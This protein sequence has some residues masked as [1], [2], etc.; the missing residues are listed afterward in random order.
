VQGA[1]VQIS[2]TTSLNFGN[3]TVGVV[4]SPQSVTLMNTGNIAL[5]VSIGVTGT[6]SGDFAQ[7]NT[8]G[9]SVA[10]GGS[11]S[12]TVTFKPLATGT[13]SAAVTITD[14]AQNSPQAVS[15]TGVGVQGAVTL[16]PTSLTFPTQVIFTTSTAQ[17][18]TL[19]N[20]GLGVLKITKGTI[21]GP[22]SYSSNCGTSVNPGNSCTLTVVFKPTTIGALTGSISITDN[23]PLSPQTIALSGTGTSVKFTPA[24]LNFGNQ[25]VGTTSLRKII[26][27]SN[28]GSVALNVSGIT[29]TGTNATDF[30]QVNNCGTSVAAGASCSI[31]VTFTPTAT[32]ARSAAVTV[33][34]N[35]GGG[36]QQVQLTGTGS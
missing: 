16:S 36:S 9:V 23:A 10:A 21:T 14:N 17:T 24:G 6:N 1:I 20:S 19:T 13:R 28:K 22:F 11:C 30:A 15:L 34:D 4:S 27:L 29:I 5:T 26:T 12:I 8:C 3:Q 18:V 31:A 33:S 2:P 35:G 25:A 32:G 7:S